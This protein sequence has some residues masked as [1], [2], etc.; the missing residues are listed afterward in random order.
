VAV[1]DF[2]AVDRGG[3]VDEVEARQQRGAESLVPV[4][5]RVLRPGSA[6]VAVFAEQAGDAPQGGHLVVIEV[7]PAVRPTRT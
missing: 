1:G 2:G 5:L 4:G 6:I 7:Q 3:D